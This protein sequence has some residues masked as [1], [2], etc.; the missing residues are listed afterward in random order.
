MMY[1]LMRKVYPR[2]NENRLSASHPELK[3]SR[4]A[5]FQAAAI[6]FILLQLLF[7]ILFCYLFGSLWIMT[8]A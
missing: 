4:S 6:N 1:L 7:L 8:A 3:A 5:F 2:A